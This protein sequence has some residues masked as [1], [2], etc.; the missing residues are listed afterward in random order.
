[1]AAALTKEFL[2]FKDMKE[3]AIVKPPQEARIIENGSEYKEENDKLVCKY[4]V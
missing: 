3:L 1:L 2:R 4:N